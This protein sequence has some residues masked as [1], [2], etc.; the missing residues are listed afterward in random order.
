M[1]RILPPV[2]FVLCL[3]AILLLT[4]WLPIAD[5]IDY[6]LTLLGVGL[7]VFGLG[8]S[9]AGK[10]HFS[11]IG[12]NIMTF[13]NPNVLVTDG[14]FRF[15]RNPMYLGFSISVLGAALLSG[16]LSSLLVFV[17]FTFL[18]DRNYIQYEEKKMIDAFG[19]SYIDYCSKVRRWL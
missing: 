14:L 8:V 7:F 1:K 6:P 4:V 5:I 3:L 17:M 9:I 18:V 2:L 19:Q 11:K 12:T 15:S 13:G 10:R 16:V